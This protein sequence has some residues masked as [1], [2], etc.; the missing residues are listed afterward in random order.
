MTRRGPAR[1]PVARGFDRVA[2]AYE[3]GRPGYSPDAVRYLV[4]V[5]GAHRGRTIVEL[6]S[7]TGKLTRQLLPYGPTLVAVEPSGAMRRIFERAVPGVLAVRGTAEEIPLPDGLADSVVAA[8]A[9]HWFRPRAASREIAR[10]L[11][12]AGTVALLWNVRDRRDRLVRR[13]DELVDRRAGPRPGR[14]RHWKAAFDPARSRFGP[15][16]LRRFRHVL[17]AE[18]E[19]VVEHALSTSRVALLKVEERRA[20]AREIR[21]LLESE[22]GGRGG[23]RVRLPTITELFWARRAGGRGR[24]RGGRGTRRTGAT[25]G[26]G[27]TSR[28]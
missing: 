16:H 26:T 1:H 28:G 15:L 27:R 17:L 2:E 25:R 24:R 14:W 23:P 18:P 7:G 5:V 3:R 11:A 8:Q 21:A 10:V 6:G 13:L 12:P 20:L 9:F 4:R 19:Q 22:A